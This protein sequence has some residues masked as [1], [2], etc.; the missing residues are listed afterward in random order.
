[1]AM[2]VALLMTLFL[3]NA[4][5][6]LYARSVLQHAADTGAR[7]GARTAGTEIACET[8][9]E[10]A[11][12]GLASLYADSASVEC[13]RDALDTTATVTAT[14]RPLFADLGPDWEVT[15]RATSVT[16]PVP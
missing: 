6:M 7:T 4:L 2:G 11:I 8:W 13:A 5:L 12:A 14:L 15:V 3:V 1:M 10:E 9:A 16:E